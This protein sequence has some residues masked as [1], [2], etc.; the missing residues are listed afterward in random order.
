MSTRI[1]RRITSSRRDEIEK[2]QEEQSHQIIRPFENVHVKFPQST[3]YDQDTAVLYLSLI[4]SRSNYLKLCPMFQLYWVKQSSYVR[5]LMEQDK[6]IPGH[7][8]RDDIYA[9]RSCVLNNDIN[10]RDIMVKL[11]ECGL[12][13]GVHFFEIR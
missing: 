3:T 11:L 5:K 13:M 4:R 9:D 1:R 7:L 8:K 10:A 12:T 6:P 2:E